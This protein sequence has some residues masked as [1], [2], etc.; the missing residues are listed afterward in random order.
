M[1]RFFKRK[2]QT[3]T[4]PASTLPDETGG[5]PIVDG[6]ASLQERGS[7]ATLDDSLSAST[8][9]SSE[10]FR[11]TTD[12]EL[13]DKSPT[14]QMGEKPIDFDF[15][16]EK[17]ENTSWMARL[18]KSMSRTGKQIGVLFGHSTIDE[19]LYDDLEAA[20]IMADAGP[21]ASQQLIKMLKQRVRSDLIDTPAAAKQALCEVLTDHLKILE[22]PFDVGVVKPLVVMIAGVN[23][24][25]K[26]TS[27]GKLAYTLQAMGAK[28]LLAAGDTFRAAAREQ[29]IEWGQRNNVSVIAQEGG[30][31][32]AVA[33]DA[34]NAGKARQVDVVMVDTAGRLPTQLHLMDELKKIKRVVS[35]A[36]NTAPHE[37][38]LVIDGNTGQNALMQVKAFDA[39]LNLTGLIVT[40]LDG[41]A[42]GGVL[43]AL[44]AGAQGCRPIPVYWVGIGE[45]INDLQPFVAS[46]FAR[47]LVN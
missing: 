38:L 11:Q 25:G 43:C 8:Y 21:Q 14:K 37:I 6:A 3:A 30:D 18:A 26:T 35:K 7:E 23:G 36:D 1:F 12:D 27:I 47:A 17:K 16:S 31:P 15:H 39:A 4:L 28:V 5:A 41:T 42:K 2:P 20:L 32:A 33:F 29:L 34:V 24:A 9:G 22:K 19:A 10:A 45:Q 44:A 40:K 46:E 13:A